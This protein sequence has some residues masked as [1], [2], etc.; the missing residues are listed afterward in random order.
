MNG[1]YPSSNSGA[2]EDGIGTPSC[3]VPYESKVIEASKEC[4]HGSCNPHRII[5]LLGCTL[6]V[7][8]VVAKLSVNKDPRLKGFIPA[9]GSTQI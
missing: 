6:T 2:C 8:V 1:I 7:V 5:A 4:L 9:V 3:T